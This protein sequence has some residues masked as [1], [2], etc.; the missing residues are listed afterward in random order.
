MATIGTTNVKMSLTHIEAN[1]ITPQSALSNVSLGDLCERGHLYAKIT[2]DFTDQDRAVLA[3]TD[4]DRRLGAFKDFTIGTLWETS[5]F[6]YRNTVYNKGGTVYRYRMG[7]SDRTTDFG[8]EFS[9]VI[10]NFGIDSIGTLSDTASSSPPSIQLRWKG[11][12]DN[13]NNR[14]WTVM[15]I[16]NRTPVREDEMTYEANT[17]NTNTRSH[18]KGN[19]NHLPTASNLG[20]YVSVKIYH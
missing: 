17:G 13:A 4:G 10:S 19:G 15:Q 20:Q 9:G 12:S 1:D 3:D 5:G 2:G 18:Y 6:Y 14:D 16:H 11:T 8:A 7:L